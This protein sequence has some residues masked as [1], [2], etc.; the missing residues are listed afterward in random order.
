MRS[1]SAGIE[2]DS[3]IGQLIGTR[4]GDSPW[5]FVV[6]KTYLETGFVADRA[7]VEERNSGKLLRGAI[8][9]GA[10]PSPSASLHISPLASFGSAGSICLRFPYATQTPKAR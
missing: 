5:N 4:R 10:N 7:L 8:S 1:W 6:P 3:G 2:Q 9:R